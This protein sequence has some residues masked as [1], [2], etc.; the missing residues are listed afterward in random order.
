M[1][2]IGFHGGGLEPVLGIV[3]P[4]RAGLGDRAIA[5]GMHPGANAYLDC[6]M[7]GVRVLLPRERLN[8]L[9]EVLSIML[10]IS[11][12]PGLLRLALRRHPRAFS[13]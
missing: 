6:G 4:F 5:A 2:P 11:N 9:P 3:N 10:R 7:V 13:N 1:L 12:N 8:V